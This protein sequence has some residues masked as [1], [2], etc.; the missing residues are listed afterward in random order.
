MYLLQKRGSASQICG[1]FSQPQTFRVGAAYRLAQPMCGKAQR[2]EFRA[3]VRRHLEQMSVMRAVARLGRRN[4]NLGRRP[5]GSAQLEQNVHAGCHIG[6]EKLLEANDAVL[7]DRD[8]EIDDSRGF[9]E[10][11]SR[12]LAVDVL[13]NDEL[14]QCVPDC[15]RV[16]DYVTHD[17]EIGQTPDATDEQAEG[18]ALRPR[19]CF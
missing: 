1:A 5:R 4:E 19:R 15:G 13:M 16:A 14:A 3:E 6:V 9:A 2:A 17:A 10:K 18:D 12:R 8:A 7:V 11:R